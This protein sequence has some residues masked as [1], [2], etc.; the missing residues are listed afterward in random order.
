MRVP[1]GLE[2]CFYGTIFIAIS[3]GDALPK[4]GAEKLGVFGAVEFFPAFLLVSDPGLA[5]VLR[6]L[7]RLC[8]E[9]VSALRSAGSSAPSFPLML[10]PGSS[11]VQNTSGQLCALPAE[12][13]W[14]SEGVGQGAKRWGSDPCCNVG[15]WGC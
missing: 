11:V 15:G 3:V 5:E 7:A 2:V 9:G 12:H 8:C 1:A 14:R 6:A 4:L 13:I 10:L